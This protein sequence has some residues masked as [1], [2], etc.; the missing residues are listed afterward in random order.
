MIMEKIAGKS[1]YTYILREGDKQIRHTISY[2]QY[3]AL[4]R[5]YDVDEYIED[6]LT[7]EMD[8]LKKTIMPYDI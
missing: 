5:Y 3:F 6:L 1:A 4:S 7:R 8:K 2:C